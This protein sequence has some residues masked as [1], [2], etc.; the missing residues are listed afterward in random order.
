LDAPVEFAVVLP[1][2][3]TSP[4]L[5]PEFVVSVGLSSTD[6]A[7]A[8]LEEHIGQK[9]TER[10]TSSYVTPEDAK[11]HCAIAPA[12]GKAASR[13]VCGD[14]A[15][16]LDHLLPFATRGL[17]LENL[18]AAD[19]H[20]ELRFESLRQ[21]FGAALRMGRT[22]AVP[23]ILKSISL[24]DARFDRPLADVAHAMGDELLDLFDD[25]DRIAIDL[26]ASAKPEQLDLKLTFA[27]RGRTSLISQATGEARQRM[28]PPTAQFY[29]LP[30][31]ATFAAYVAASDPKYVERPRALTEALVEGLLAHFEVGT[32][33]RRDVRAAFDTMFNINSPMVMAYGNVAAAEK[34]TPSA[35]DRL[36][37]AFGW[38]VYGL[39]APSEPYKAA[40]KTATR[41]SADKA[42]A[43]GIN[44]LFAKLGESTIETA[45]A[46][47]KDKNKSTASDWVKLRSKGIAGMPA[48]SEVISVE[49]TAEATKELLSS[50]V[51]KSKAKPAGAAPA[52]AVQALFAIVPD[53]TRTWFI[54]A[55]DDKTLLDR[56]KAVLTTSKVPRLST[57]SDINGLRGQAVNQA[58]F[59]TL[60]TAKGWLQMALLERGKSAKDAE[61]LFSSVPHHGNTPMPYRVV[62]VGDD[63]RQNVELSTTIPRAVFDDAAA[64]VPTLMTLSPD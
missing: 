59:A 11:V 34:V 57:R 37:M 43:K 63:K 6:K 21:H 31:D 64:A 14:R 29:D 56:S 32:G 54:F 23:T 51:R 52:E 18:G 50:S 38:R 27:Y 61:S 5:K 28:T 12:I 9:L 53:G 55:M 35:R 20:A 58:G 48:G 47:S 1:D 60:G 3:D 16:S 2:G 17:P 42:M 8:L 39:E 26:N 10:P 45:K 33:L 36:G 15:R 41:L 62:V 25:V 19:L 4:N 30:A 22:V 40:L 49:F 7:R 13:L 24:S 44:D 46:N